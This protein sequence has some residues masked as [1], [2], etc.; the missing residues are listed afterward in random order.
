MDFVD[1]D[2]LKVVLQYGIYA[3]CWGCVVIC[4][5]E[6][7]VFAVMKGFSAFRHISK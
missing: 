2:L 4:P 5:L 6:F 3:S 1:M 7:I